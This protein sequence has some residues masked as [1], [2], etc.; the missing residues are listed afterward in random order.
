M[1]LLL[2]YLSILIASCLAVVS[3]GCDGE[4]PKVVRKTLLISQWND[5]VVLDF[6]DHLVK[7]A[8]AAEITIVNGMSIVLQTLF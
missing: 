6:G 8:L 5:V 3:Q 1:G 4:D 2:T 7:T